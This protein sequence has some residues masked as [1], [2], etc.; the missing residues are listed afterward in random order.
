M[1]III[2]V[3]L[4]SLTTTFAW[5]QSIDEKT[6]IFAS[7]LKLPNIPGLAIKASRAKSGPSASEAATILVQQFSNPIRAAE[8][9]NRTFGFLSDKLDHSIR[10]NVAR[11]AYEDASKEVAAE[12][13]K[14]IKGTQSIEID[15]AAA[16]Q[17]AT[18]A[19]LCAWGSGSPTIA[20]LGMSR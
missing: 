18:F 1:R 14:L 2:A 20:A 15:I 6:C 16:S 9:L 3:I 13:A 8:D 19:Y 5:P 17:T 7:A 12:I 4:F 11:G 10:T